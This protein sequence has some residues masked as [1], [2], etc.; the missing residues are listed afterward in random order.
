MRQ[1]LIT[2]ATGG[3]GSAVAYALSEHGH[4]PLLMGR[5]QKKL[6][7]LADTLGAPGFARDLNCGD[8]LVRV[9]SDIASVYGRLDGIVH[10][11][12]ISTPTPLRYLED[13]YLYAV[14][15]TNQLTTI[16]LVKALINPK[17]RAEGQVSFTAISSVAA[18]RGAKATSAYAASKA[19]V[20]GMVR[21]LAVELAPENVRVNSVAAGWVSTPMTAGAAVDIASI[22][23]R[24]PLGIG[25]PEHVAHAVVF[26]THAEWVTGITLPV[27]GGYAAA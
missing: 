19:A 7:A 10:C 18:I 12:G 4:K 17:V 21:A 13:D 8:D 26:L 20:D 24:H 6:S 23:A 22:K 11:A 1:Y 14:T 27:D 15:A 9:V 5:D 2:G 16:R 3:I 25:R